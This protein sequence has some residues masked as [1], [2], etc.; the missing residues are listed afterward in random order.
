MLQE[1]GVQPNNGGKTAS[2][3]EMEGRRVVMVDKKKDGEAY[4]P[5]SGRKEGL[6]IG[7]GDDRN[8]R[9]GRFLRMGG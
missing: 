5:V 8:C 2:V 6:C 3:Q 7:G 1:R 9:W 4:V